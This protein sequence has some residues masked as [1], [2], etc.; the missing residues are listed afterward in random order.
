MFLCQ[1]SPAFSTAS[2]DGRGQPGIT[3]MLQNNRSAAGGQPGYW[4]HSE[5]G[6]QAPPRVASPGNPV[7]AG[8]YRVSVRYEDGGYEQPNAFAYAMPPSGMRRDAGPHASAP[9]QVALKPGD[10]RFFSKSIQC[11][12]SSPCSFKMYQLPADR[13]VVFVVDEDV[14]LEESYNY[15]SL[16]IVIADVVELPDRKS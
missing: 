13:N 8:N 14:K 10:V 15:S 16:T 9:S 2:G 4:V 5:N 12:A 3:H 1:A 11:K 7:N 6:I